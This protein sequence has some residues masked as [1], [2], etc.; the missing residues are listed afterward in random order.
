[1]VTHERLIL[2]FIDENLVIRGACAN[3]PN[4]AEGVK[5]SMVA[6]KQMIEIYTTRL[7]KNSYYKGT[8]VNLN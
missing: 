6:M 2:W 5:N 3:E 4:T 1:M 7:G 8:I